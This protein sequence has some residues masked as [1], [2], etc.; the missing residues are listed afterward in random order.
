[1]KRFIFFI[2]PLL[3]LGLFTS[4]KNTPEDKANHIVDRI[5]S[6]L[7]LNETQEKELRG[8]AQEMVKE[9]KA[10]KQIREKRHEEVFQLFLS[11][12]ITEDQVEAIIEKKQDQREKVLKKFLPDLLSFHATLSQGQKQE[13]VRVAKKFKDRFAP[14]E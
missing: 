4:C 6:E 7:I 10:N 9:F 13:A 2:L 8:I 3:S 5:S 11:D 12:R 14:K 1:M